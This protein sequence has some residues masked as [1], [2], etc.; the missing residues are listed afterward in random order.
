MIIPTNDPVEE[1]AVLTCV[2]A[3]YEFFVKAFPE[4]TKEKN[5]YLTEEQILTT[6]AL[7]SSDDEYAE[8]MAKQWG[9]DLDAPAS[10]LAIKLLGGIVNDSV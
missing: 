8:L 9:V 3:T 6:Y 5:L 2:L 4:I 1:K 7:C 10:D